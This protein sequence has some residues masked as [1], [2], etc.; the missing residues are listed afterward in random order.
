MSG[1]GANGAWEAGVIWGLA[2]YG[3]PIDYRWDVLSGISAGGFNSVFGVGFEPQDVLKMTEFI[4]DAWLNLKNE[5]IW[6]NR[7]GDINTILHSESSYL[8]TSPAENS[9]RQLMSQH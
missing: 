7:A 4:S 1:G 5:D 2:H 6:L 3:D 8:D 9:I